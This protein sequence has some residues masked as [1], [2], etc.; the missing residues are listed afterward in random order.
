M[1]KTIPIIT[2]YYLFKKAF[3][4]LKKLDKKIWDKQCSFKLQFSYYQRIFFREIIFT[5]MFLNLI[6][7]KKSISTLC[8]E[9]V[10]CV[11]PFS[12]L[13]ILMLCGT[14]IRLSRIWNLVL[15]TSK[16]FLP[17]NFAKYYISQNMFKI[18]LYVIMSI[19]LFNIFDESCAIG[20][21]Q[22]GSGSKSNRR[23]TNNCPS[24]SS[25]GPPS[26]IDCKYL[27]F[28]CKS[29]CIETLHDVN[30]QK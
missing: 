3:Q 30:L 21:R 11:W 1:K 29:K 15:N 26:K 19:L 7:R 25:R 12:H 20:N 13:V 5:K 8:C 4:K 10:L 2:T 23:R 22:R 16:I 28:F 17:I 27:C 24:V 9:W 14:V 6:S 18:K